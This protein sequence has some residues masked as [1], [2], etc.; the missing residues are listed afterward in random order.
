MIA[1]S[2]SSAQI[3]KLIKSI[4]EV[5]YSAIKDGGSTIRDFMF[6]EDNKGNFQNKFNVYDRNGLGCHIC[7]NKIQKLIINLRSTYFCSYCQR[8]N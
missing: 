7:K 5:L 1:K 3:K 2:I 6:N 8:K 4:K